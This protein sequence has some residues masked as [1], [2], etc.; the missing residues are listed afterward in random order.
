MDGPEIK[1]SRQPIGSKLDG[2]EGL[3]WTVLKT[4]YNVLSNRMH[5][6][7]KCSWEARE[8]GA[9]VADVVLNWLIYPKSKAADV[10]SITLT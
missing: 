8:D 1:K 6:L 4:E 3:K 7:W 9:K 2:F 5:A 10:I